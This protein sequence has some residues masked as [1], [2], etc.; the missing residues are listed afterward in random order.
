M[1]EKSGRSRSDTD[2]NEYGEE[3]DEE[4]EEEEEDV[5]LDRILS[6]KIFLTST[7]A[8]WQT[9]E[10][11]R[12]VFEY[13]TS[14]TS[15]SAKMRENSSVEATFIAAEMKE[16]QKKEALTKLKKNILKLTH[17]STIP[18][19]KPVFLLLPSNLVQEEEIKAKTLKRKIWPRGKVK[20]MY[21]LFEMKR[22]KSE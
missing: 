10:K 5:E 14:N 13:D 6:A 9:P 11:S 17:G 20:N 16:R 21:Y 22:G 4:E 8:S 18:L 15:N 3:V 1:S 12:S 7:Q 19:T 2:K